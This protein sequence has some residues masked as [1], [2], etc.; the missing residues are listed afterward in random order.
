MRSIILIYLFLIVNISCNSILN[1]RLSKDP[2]VLDIYNKKEIHSLELI[3]GFFD[4]FISAS[5]INNQEIGKAYFE[6]FELINSSESLE[7]MEIYLGLAHSEDTKKLIM[8][9]KD[10]GIFNEIWQYD[11]NYDF[12]TKD[13]S[14]VFLSPSVFG[15]YMQ[16]LELKGKSNRSLEEYSKS[17]KNCACIAPSQIAFFM[18]DY[19]KKVDFQ[20][21]VNRLLFAVHYITIVSEQKYKK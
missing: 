17:I 4:D 2:D 9:L 11:Y 7:D 6:Y 12:Q 15:K 10:R 14:S 19:Y 8:E 3:L 20:K 16:F 18:K 5:T 13:T 21:E 1:I